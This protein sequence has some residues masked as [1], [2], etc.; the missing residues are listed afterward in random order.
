MVMA[1]AGLAMGCIDTLSNLQLVKI[2]QKDSAVFLQV[3]K[4]LVHVGPNFAPLFVCLYS[5]TSPLVRNSLRSI[6]LAMIR[7]ILL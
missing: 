7:Y 6:V 4:G 3:R 5:P 1:V 2:Y